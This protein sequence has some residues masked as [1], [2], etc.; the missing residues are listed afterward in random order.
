LLQRHPAPIFGANV[1]RLRADEAIE[2][3][4][5][6]AMGRPAGHPANGKGWGEEVGG[7][8]QA[9]NLPPGGAITL[10]AL[11]RTIGWIGHA[12]EQY[13]LERLIRPRAKYVGRQPVEEG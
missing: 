6:E 5:L 11:G 1:D 12:I 7:L 9:L 4:L 10:F 8:A 13:Q 3:L 2:A